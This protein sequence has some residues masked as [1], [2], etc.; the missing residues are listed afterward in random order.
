M[1]NHVKRVWQYLGLV[2]RPT[3][4]I[5]P[6]PLPAPPTPQ[7]HHARRKRGPKPI[8]VVERLRRRLKE[9]PNGCWEFQGYCDAWGY[10]QISAGEPPHMRSAH[11]VMWEIVHGPIPESL[12]V[13]HSCDNPPC[14]NPA[15]L[16]LGTHKDNMADM[17]VKGRSPSARGEENVNAKLTWEQVKAIRKDDRP[18]PAIAADYGVTPRCIC[19]IQLRQTWKVEFMAECLFG[20]PAEALGLSMTKVTLDDV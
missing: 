17:A 11:R 9:A 16:F 1:G 20:L 7:E 6:E 13:L 15:H 3:A 19:Q 2:L 4:T 10:G 8:L 5:D 14:A 18:Y 12:K